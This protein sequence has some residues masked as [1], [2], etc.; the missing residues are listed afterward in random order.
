M[1]YPEKL[2]YLEIKTDAEIR[3]KLGDS[4]TKLI[5]SPRLTRTQAQRLE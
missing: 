1:D 3:K 2:S 5:D 4:Q